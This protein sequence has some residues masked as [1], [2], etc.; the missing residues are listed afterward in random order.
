MRASSETMIW[1]YNVVG[2]LFGFVALMIVAQILRIQLSPQAHTFREQ[3][4]IY[5][6][7]WRT[8][9]P[10]RGLIYDRWGN[11]LAGNQTVYEL[12]VE[13]KDVRNPETI[14]FTLMGVLKSDYDRIYAAASRKYSL[15]PEKPAVYAVLANNV[16]EEQKARIE[17]MAKEIANQ[18]VG[19]DQTPPSLRG[20]VFRPTLKRSYPEEEMAS[21]I[22]GF[23][24]DE[25]VGFG[26]E[27]KFN[28]LLAGTVQKI[29][30]PL[31]PNRVEEVPE[32]ASGSSLVLTIDR[33]IQSAM[34]KLLDEAIEESG[35]DGGVILVA[36]P[37][38]GEILAM[39]TTPRLDL[40]N[41][42]D[43]AR[44][45][46]GSTPFNKAVSQAYETGSVFKVLTMA[47]ALDSGA[48]TLDTVF[49]DTGIFELG[50]IYIYN[51]NSGAWGPQ[52]MTGCMRH[53][54]NVCL[55]WVAAELTPSRF[56]SYM[57]AF[58][59][60]R[61]TGIEIAGEDPGRLK[62]PGDQDWY[63]ADLATNSFGQGLSATTIQMVMAISSLANDGKMMAPHIVRSLVNN[64]RQYNTSPQVVGLPVSVETAHTITEMLAESLETESSDALVDG[65]RVAGKTGTAEIPT[66]YGYTS[67]MTNAS[68]VGWGPVDDPRFLVYVWL[69]KPM[70]SPWGSVV[71]A[72][73]F[74]Q[75]AERLVVLM[76]IPPDHVREELG[77][78]NR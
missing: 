10:A 74:R 69:E 48:V 54:L 18:P 17:S 40:N 16:T 41:F 31:D 24:N 44:V 46:P 66:P 51:W 8:V 57:Q 30:V 29:W 33:E 64:G 53:S 25:G 5:A 14:A 62:M 13:L 61:L 2:M 19:R 58:G 7:E 73:V 55:A 22:L 9:K 35:S 56:Y 50:G 27:A 42:G 52:D 23:V 21:N 72:P 11:L 70:T 36:D 20:L 59:F 49:V 75:A 68:F 39:A 34:E 77:V 45:F 32:V 67:N 3:G 76:N 78:A 28:D 63:D 4:D 1:R 47:A 6:G 37:Q 71:A 65:Y 43:Y 12:G 15:D 38:T 60:G 26:V